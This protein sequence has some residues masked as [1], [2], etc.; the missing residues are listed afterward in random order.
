MSGVK[1]NCCETWLGSWAM[2]PANL[3]SVQE[4]TVVEVLPTSIWDTSS[5]MIKTKIAKLKFD[6][7]STEDTTLCDFVII[8]LHCN[9][10]R[11]LQS[12]C[13]LKCL[14][15]CL[16]S[17]DQSLRII[18]SFK[19]PWS[20]S[21]QHP[22]CVNHVESPSV[23]R[24]M[25]SL[26]TGWWCWLSGLQCVQPNS[27]TL[28]GWYN[29]SSNGGFMVLGL[30]QCQQTWTHINVMHGK[31]PTIFS[32][33]SPHVLVVVTY[34]LLSNSLKFFMATSKVCTQFRELW[35]QEDPEDQDDSEQVEADE[36]AAAECLGLS[37]YWL[38]IE[39]DPQL[40]D[41]EVIWS[42]TSSSITWTSWT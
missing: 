1:L 35:H 28:N 9:S 42:C 13:Y 41:L 17:R 29:P 2:L 25:L 3:G 37:P 24:I 31:W 30:P 14:L 7:R 11:N 33:S 36:A 39:L 4:P 10:R 34:E 26:K 32:I 22:K 23:S 16:K 19:V 12:V 6:P 20:C 21:W 5:N 38:K 40:E 18:T 8:V 27:K 15:L